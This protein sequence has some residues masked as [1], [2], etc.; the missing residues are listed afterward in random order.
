MGQTVRSSRGTRP[1]GCPHE[2]RGDSSLFVSL[3]YAT[4]GHRLTG[5]SIRKMLVQLCN[6]AGIKKQMSSHRIQHSAITTALD[7]TDGNERAE[8]AKTQPSP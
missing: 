7:A 1:R 4:G 3:N 2:W 5:D 8:S 6:Q